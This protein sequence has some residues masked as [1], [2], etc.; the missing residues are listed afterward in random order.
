MITVVRQTVERYA[1]LE[2][3]GAVAVGL[4]G[5]ADSVSLLSVLLRLAPE[6]GLSLRAIHVNHGIRGEAADRDEAFCRELCERLGVPL[7]CFSFDVPALAAQSGCGLEETGRRCRYECFQ[8]I[9]D[10]FGCRIATAHTL[11]DSVETVL[12]NLTRGSGLAGL[13][14]IPPVRGNIIRPLIGVVREQVEAYCAENALEYMTD[15]TN[16]D[17]AYSRNLIRREIIP[18]LRRINPSLHSAVGRM[19]ETLREDEALL[20]GMAS[21]LSDPGDIASLAALEQP[22]RRRAVMR[23]IEGESGYAPEHAHVLLCEECLMNASG[24]VTLPGGYYFRADGGR[25]SV[26]K[27]TEPQSYERWQLDDIKTETVLPDGRVLLLRRFPR[28]QYEPRQKNKDCLFKN[29]VT[30]DIMN[31]KLSARNRREGDRFAP[32]GAG[33]TKRLKKLL[34]DAHIPQEERERRVILLD[35]EGILWVE[36]FGA[37]EWARVRPDDA[38][39]IVPIICEKQNKLTEDKQNG[40]GH[41]G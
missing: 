26:E 41:E 16:S 18:L 17:T 37:A 24:A 12:F 7:D 3:G 36:G 27:K 4:S 32:V 1:M 25:I 14:G 30:C 28:E 29:A 9:A 6:Y 19:S 8:E 38:E 11:S 20:E 5:G 10:R 23:L 22:L 39:I 15:E 40:N 33:M 34:C 13:G 21:Q 35:G 31:G 2:K